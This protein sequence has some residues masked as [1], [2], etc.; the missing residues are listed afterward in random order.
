MNSYVHTVYLCAAYYC[1]KKLVDGTH[2]LILHI[3]FVSYKYFLTFE[4]GL[5]TSLSR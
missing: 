1:Q 5:I 2:L 4:L 3:F